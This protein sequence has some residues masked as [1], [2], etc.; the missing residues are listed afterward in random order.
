[1]KQDSLSTSQR[2][3]QVQR[4][5]YRHYGLD[6]TVQRDARFHACLTRTI[7]VWL[8]TYPRCIILCIV[9]ILMYS[10]KFCIL[11]NIFFYPEGILFFSTNNNDQYSNQL[12]TTILRIVVSQKDITCL[13]IPLLQLYIFSRPKVLPCYTLELSI[14]I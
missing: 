13:H 12:K 14:K 10:Y 8:D 2:C 3:P 1:M 6:E 5:R 7:F 11:P 4:C 9:K